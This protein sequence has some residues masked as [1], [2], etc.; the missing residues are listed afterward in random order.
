MALELES[1][2]RA[3]DPRIREVVSADYGDDQSEVAIASSM[4]IS[5]ASRSTT[6]YLVVYAVAGEG[7]VIVPG[8]EMP[9][10]TVGAP[11]EYET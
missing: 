4:G 11:E 9:S 6:C 2:V 8:E 1:Q 5:A 10:V 7:E 3:G